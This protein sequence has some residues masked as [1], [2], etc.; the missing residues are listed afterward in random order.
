VAS[1]VDA[2][3]HSALHMSTAHSCFILSINVPPRAGG[4]AGA[5]RGRAP[6][7]RLPL[8][9]LSSRKRSKLK[10]KCKGI[11]RYVVQE[12]SLRRA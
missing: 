8:D 11:H 5:S 10:I 12:S 4:R 7:C 6:S 9:E 2:L 3:A 1:T